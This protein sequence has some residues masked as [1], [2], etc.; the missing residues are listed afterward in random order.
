[1]VLFLDMTFEF[2]DIQIPNK[3]SRFDL[4]EWEELDHTCR[5]LGLIPVLYWKLLLLVLEGLCG[6]KVEPRLKSMCKT[7]GLVLALH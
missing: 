4:G 1:M 3:T 5:C 7:L 6:G 2:S